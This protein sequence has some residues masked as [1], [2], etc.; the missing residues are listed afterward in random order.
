ME[1]CSFIIRFH[2]SPR[3]LLRSEARASD[4]L[5][6]FPEYKTPTLSYE[7]HPNDLKFGYLQAFRGRILTL[8]HPDESHIYVEI[9]EILRR[10]RFY[11]DRGPPYIWPT[12]YPAV[13]GGESVVRLSLGKLRVL[14]NQL[15]VV[16]R[17]NTPLIP[18]QM[19]SST[20]HGF[21]G[22]W[23]RPPHPPK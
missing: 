20:D 1:R 7:A 4:L 21:F 10:L 19:A 8:A 16:K 6:N 12:C 23:V 22:S 2:Q 13:T 17:T 11:I 3:Q 18:Q 9:W 5:L 14:I 15:Q